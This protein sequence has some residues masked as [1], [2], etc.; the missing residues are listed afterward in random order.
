MVTNEPS[1]VT[2]GAP[3]DILT[4]KNIPVGH[5]EAKDLGATLTIRAIN[6][7]RDRQ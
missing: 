7:S 3:D 4:K 6:L 5:I 1:R 2:C